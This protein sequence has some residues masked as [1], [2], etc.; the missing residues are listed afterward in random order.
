MKNNIL[1]EIRILKNENKISKARERVAN[2]ILKNPEKV[3]GM[4]KTTLARNSGVGYSVLEG[5]MKSDLNMDY[6]TF[7]HKITKLAKKMKGDVYYTHILHKIFHKI[8]NENL[9]LME[10]AIAEGIIRNYKTI[11][12][13]TFYKFSYNLGIKQTSIVKFL[14]NHLEYEKYEDLQNRIN[15]E[16]VMREILN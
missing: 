15:R 8:K 16:L 13:T 5:F 3:A 4:K 2:Y 14:K 7:N 1:D 12:E 9:N 10:E 11:P 6:Q